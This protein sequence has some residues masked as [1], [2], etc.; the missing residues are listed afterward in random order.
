MPQSMVKEHKDSVC[1][2]A[3]SLIERGVQG[4]RSQHNNY[5]KMDLEV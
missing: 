1:Y 5:Y 2:H 3:V 4:G